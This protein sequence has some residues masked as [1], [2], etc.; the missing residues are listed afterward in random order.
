MQKLKVWVDGCIDV[1]KS[2][3]RKSFD[4]CRFNHPYEVQVREI[5]PPRKNDEDRDMPMAAMFHF[6]GGKRSRD[7]CISFPE[8]TTKRFL[9]AHALP[10]WRLRFE[11]LDERGKTIGFAEIEVQD[12][13]R[14][15]SWNLLLCTPSSQDAM[16]NDHVRHSNTNASSNAP[17]VRRPGFLCVR[18][19]QTKYGQQHLASLNRLESGR[20]QGSRGLFD[21]R[22]V[23]GSGE[24][25][26]RDGNRKRVMIVTRGTRGDVQPIV[27]LAR[28]LAQEPFGCEVTIVTELEFKQ[29]VRDANQGLGPGSIHFRPCGG[30]T[31]LQTQ[32][33]LS[34]KVLQMGQRVEAI[35]AVALS[36]SEQNFF[37]SEGCF[38]FWACE[39]RPDFIV[40]TFTTTQVAMIISEA[41]Q[42]PIVGFFLQPAHEIEQRANP[43][44]VRDQLLGP[45]REVVDS[46]EFNAM[47]MQMME[48]L[49][50]AGYTLNQLRTSRGLGPCPRGISD[51]FLQYA[52]LTRQGVPQIVPISEVVLGE[53]AQTLR[54]QNMTPTDFIFLRQEHEEGLDDECSNF[55]QHS[56]DNGR[57]VVAITFSSMPVGERKILEV[58]A[59]ICGKCRPQADPGAGSHR[60]AVIALVK[61]QDFDPVPRSSPLDDEVRSL[62]EGQRLLV[63]KRGANFGALF[64]RLDAVILHGGLGVTSE[65]LVAGIPAIVS[66]IL[67]LDQRYWAARI[68][69]LGCGPSGIYI[70]DLIVAPEAE[71]PPR[72]VALMEQ[73]LDKR[74]GSLE[75]DAVPWRQRAKD[76]QREISEALAGRESDG[77]KLNAEVVYKQGLAAQ[78]IS[79]AYGANRSCIETGGR[80]MSCCARC[81][82]GVLRWLLCRQLPSCIRLQL[83]CVRWFLHCGCCPRRLCCC[84]RRASGVDQQSLSTVVSFPGHDTTNARNI[85][86]DMT[87]SVSLSTP[88]ASLSTPLAP[89]AN[90]V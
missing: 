82:R 7:G 89:Q 71:K 59:A 62:Q 81:C 22:H 13:E 65:A 74:T 16:Y 10:G 52:E 60:P 72:V 76:V 24:E 44:T 64:P 61:G 6:Q 20:S 34:L 21:S 56:R 50:D 88:L 68:A 14:N 5:E 23:P 15:K 12:L 55:I 69:E 19:G 49:P 40:F 18:T 35:Q 54:D 8:E 78:P 17:L 42:I 25:R 73:A 29:F 63:L 2:G 47:L 77:I 31:M 1:P 53:H 33:K 70:D 36:K 9:E 45:M 3:F 43:A 37:S 79:N 66:G 11:V 90:T 58:A 83:K 85:D 38:F 84:P 27:A 67:L 57:Q 28:G 46:S 26:P 39:E 51:E 30:N 87:N 41:L 4:V 48:R 80:Q 86:I 32:S 75:N